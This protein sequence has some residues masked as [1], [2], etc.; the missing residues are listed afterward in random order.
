[1]RGCQKATRR[2]ST[3]YRS[4]PGSM[5]ARTGRTRPRRWRAVLRRNS[6]AYLAWYAFFSRVGL[7]GLPQG[8][9]RKSQSHDATVT[10]SD[11]GIDKHE[12]SR[13]QKVAAIPEPDSGDTKVAGRSRS[14]LLGLRMRSIFGSEY[15]NA[16]DGRGALMWHPGRS[17]GPGAPDWNA[18]HASAGAG[19]RATVCQCIRSGSVSALYHRMPA[20][21][22]LGDQP[23]TTPGRAPFGLRSRYFPYPK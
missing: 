6:D 11:L 20:S 7:L 12:S 8:G 21:A 22:S 14:P 19:L 18:R 5:N 9:D 23:S 2:Q 16:P 1:M 3:R 13:W 4:A 15:E 10:L 17:Y